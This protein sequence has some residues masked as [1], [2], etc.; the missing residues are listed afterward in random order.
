M[1]QTDADAKPMQK[2]KIKVTFQPKKPIVSVPKQIALCFLRNKWRNI[3]RFLQLSYIYFLHI[4]RILCN[5]A[6]VLVH[7]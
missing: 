6:H 2:Y 5:F 1:R 4:S 3:N 7:I